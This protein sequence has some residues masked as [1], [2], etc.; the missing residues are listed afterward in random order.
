MKNSIIVLI[1]ILIVATPGCKT[2][3]GTSLTGAAVALASC[4]AAK[5]HPRIAPWMNLTG[6]V[7]LGFAAT[8]PPSP[9]E[10]AATLRAVTEHVFTSIETDAIWALTVGVYD[11][12]WRAEMTP[13]RR[14]E[15]RTSLAVIGT[16]LKRGSLC[17]RPGADAAAQRMTAQV[18]ARELYGAQE[19]GKAVADELA[20]LSR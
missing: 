16:A 15:V 5:E 18:R 4:E 7:F 12:V 17:A 9:A 11:L 19:A 1:A 2:N 14:E 20:K 8:D 10:L 6:E 13:Q 3:T